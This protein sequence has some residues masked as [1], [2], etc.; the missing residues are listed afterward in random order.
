MLRYH[1]KDLRNKPVILIFKNMMSG[2]IKKCAL[3][4]IPLVLI[5]ICFFHSYIL[6]DLESRKNVISF[7]IMYYRHGFSSRLESEFCWEL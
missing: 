2:L 3:F 5:Y 6:S 4:C 7:N 1:P